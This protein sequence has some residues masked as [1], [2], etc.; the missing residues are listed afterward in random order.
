MV[1]III[2]GMVVVVVVQVLSAKRSSFAQ[3]VQLN[4][5]HKLQA[6]R[7]ETLNPKP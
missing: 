3:R 1:T 5:H 4:R 7:R 6:P 2:I